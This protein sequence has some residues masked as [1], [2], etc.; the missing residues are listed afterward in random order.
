MNNKLNV[1][2]IEPHNNKEL[3]QYINKKYNVINE[4]SL[5]QL[6]GYIYSLI[7]VVIVAKVQNIKLGL[8]IVDYTLYCGKEIIC[9]KWNIYNRQWYLSRHLFRAG[10]NV[11]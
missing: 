3:V 6:E 8:E 2:I 10:A 5:K 7:D 9:I 11:I 1:Y 4:K